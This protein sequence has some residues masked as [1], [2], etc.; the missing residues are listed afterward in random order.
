MLITNGNSMWGTVYDSID[1]TVL[2]LNIGDCLTFGFFVPSVDS[3][4]LNIRLPILWH[5]IG[6]DGKRLKLLSYFFFEHTGYWSV[7]GSTKAVTW[8][9]SE[10]RH[11][12]NNKFLY[13]CF[14]ENERNAILTTEVKTKST[15]ESYIVTH[16]KLYVPGLEDIEIIPEHLK[17]VDGYTKY[18]IR[19]YVEGRLPA[20][21]VWRKNKMGW[22]S[23]RKRWIDRFDKRRIGEML[24]EPR[25]DKYFNVPAIRELWRK[26]PY[27]YAIERFLNVE[28]FMRLFDA[29]VT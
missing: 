2:Q 22:P 8:E 17:I 7:E 3:S 5:V 4:D 19:K 6:K 13:D 28:I 12:L 24:K 26:N 21:V 16:D 9:N 25:S 18:P 10:I 20:S 14:D 29:S 27:H 11:D 15:G 1:E 23:P